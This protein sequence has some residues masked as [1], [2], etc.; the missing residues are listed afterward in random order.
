MTK[1]QNRLGMSWAKLK[2]CFIEIDFYRGKTSLNKCTSLFLK[3]YHFDACSKLWLGTT[4]LVRQVVGWVGIW[5]LDK[6]E[7]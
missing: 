7:I 2:V 3:I 6:L 1:N 4:F 5:V